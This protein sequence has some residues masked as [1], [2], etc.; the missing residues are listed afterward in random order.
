MGVMGRR[1]EI[2]PASTVARAWAPYPIMLQCIFVTCI[3]AGEVQP[4]NATR[5]CV[6]TVSV[7]KPKALYNRFEILSGITNKQL[8]IDSRW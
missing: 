8:S 6:G 2:S 5:H 3:L 7:R 4:Q 1:A